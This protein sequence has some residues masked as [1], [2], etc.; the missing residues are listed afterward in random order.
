LDT[1]ENMTDIN[2]IAGQVPSDIKDTTKYKWF[3]CV[4]DGE[5]ADIQVFSINSERTIAVFS[6]NP[7]IIPIEPDDAAIGDLYVDGVFT[8]PS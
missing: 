7:I 5:V 8:E 1:G 6:S 4:C 2:P 3:A